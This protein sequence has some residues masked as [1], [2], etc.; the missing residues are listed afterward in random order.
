MLELA[1]DRYIS[2]VT[3]KMFFAKKKKEEE[4]KR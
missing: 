1:L 4:R 2:K 3:S